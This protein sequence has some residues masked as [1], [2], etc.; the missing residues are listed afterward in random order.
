MR[1]LSLWVLLGGIALAATACASSGTTASSGAPPATNVT[2][3]WAGTW[4]FEPPSAGNG[5]ATVNFTQDGSTVKGNIETLSGPH[6]GR[7]GFFNATMSGNDI[8]ITGPD[9]TGWLKVNGNE[10]TGTINGI[11][12]ARIT[13][14]KQ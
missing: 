13:L 4:T 10:M 8:H 7:A 9:A 2:G 12:P 14:K 5:Q 6:R 1:K 3:R 11:L